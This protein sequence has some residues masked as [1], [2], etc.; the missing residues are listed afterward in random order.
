VPATSTPSAKG[1]AV[2]PDAMTL[3]EGALLEPLP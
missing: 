3:E 1:P 2:W